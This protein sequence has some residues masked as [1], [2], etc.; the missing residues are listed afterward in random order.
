MH[1]EDV[2]EAITLLL[3]APQGGHIYNLSAPEH[4]ARQD[5]YPEVARQLGLQAPT[6]RLEEQGS[7]GKI[8]DGS[9]ICRELAFV[10]Q[11]P[12]PAKMP[13]K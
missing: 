8:I 5:F 11:Y 3:Q 12:D 10:Y 13:L 6:F 1:L 7:Q 2:I 4:P 9:K